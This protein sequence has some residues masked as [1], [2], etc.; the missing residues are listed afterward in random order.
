VLQ[1]LSA[2]KDPTRR[3]CLI[4]GEPGLQKDNIAALLHFGSPNR[5][6]PMVQVGEAGRQAGRQIGRHHRCL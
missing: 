6:K 3:S 1:V 5:N 2:A 4:F